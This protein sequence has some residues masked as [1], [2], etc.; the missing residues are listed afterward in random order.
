MSS[1]SNSIK[2][3][4]T[5]NSQIRIDTTI[6]SISALPQALNLDLDHRFET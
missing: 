2:S 6:N 5:T 3:L 4:F 1:Q